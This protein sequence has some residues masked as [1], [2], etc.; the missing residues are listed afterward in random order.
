PDNVWV[1]QHTLSINGK[2]REITKS[3]LMTVADA[4]G[5]GKGEKIIN[6]I[7]ETVGNWQYYA[8]KAGVPDQ[9]KKSIAETLA[10]FKFQG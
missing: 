3:D 8:Q 2:N 4:N 7:K 5:V 6:E 10:V 1:S 9:L